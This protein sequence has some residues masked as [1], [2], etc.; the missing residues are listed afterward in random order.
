MAFLENGLSLKGGLVPNIAIG[1]GAAIFITILAPSVASALRPVAKAAIKGG[2]TLFEK[3]RETFAEVEEIIEDIVAEAKAELSAK[4][5][6]VMPET[7]ETTVKG[8][9][10]G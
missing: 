10:G 6:V 2:M 1:I 8:E 5:D 4:Q 3:G 9:T 7:A